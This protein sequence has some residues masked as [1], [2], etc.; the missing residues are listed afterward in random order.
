MMGMCFILRRNKGK[1]L[2]LTPFVDPKQASAWSDE[3]PVCW[4]AS[5]GLTTHEKDDA[6]FTLYTQIDRGVDRWIQDKRYVPRLLL[7]ALVFLIVYFFFSLAVRD[8]LPM[9]DE[10]L[11][12]FG[13][14][15]ALW[16]ALGKRDKKGELAMKRRM[17]LKQHASRSEFD[18]LEG[19]SVYETYLDTCSYLD[20][21]DIADRLALVSDQE[22]P[23][24][25]IPKEQRGEWVQ[26]LRALLDQ[27]FA[28]TDRQ[29]F[30]RVVRVRAARETGKPDEALGARLVKLAMHE[31][32]DL[33]L[34]ALM[35]A[36]AKQ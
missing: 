2:F 4:Y 15:I 28:I 3:E 13:C 34:L 19:L 33:P 23:P 16:Y 17:V 25:D 27:H 36:V 9:I 22:L 29:F 35:V 31:E 26:K 30:A 24:L 18:L 6:L 10:L 12:A 21:L 20:T 32:A 11:I 8:P 5:T 14:S 1:S 7:S